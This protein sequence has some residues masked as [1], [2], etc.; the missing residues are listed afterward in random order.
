VYQ[1]ETDQNCNL[2]QNE[3]KDIMKMKQNVREQHKSELEKLRNQVTDIA[4]NYK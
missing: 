4:K 2:F 1:K 3:L